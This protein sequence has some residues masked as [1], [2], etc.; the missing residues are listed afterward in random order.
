[1]SKK[2][3]RF[4]ATLAKTGLSRPHTYRLIRDGKHPRPI[5]IGDRA[6]GFIEDE[7]D[8]YIEQKIAVR[9]GGRR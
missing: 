8:S 6:V 4:P 7:I 1:V 2:V 9:D 3:L 5:K